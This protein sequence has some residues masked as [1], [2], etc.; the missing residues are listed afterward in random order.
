MTKLLAVL[1][2]AAVVGV[3][4]AEAGVNHRQ[5]D[6][7]ARIAHN[8]RTGELTGREAARLRAEQARIRRE[9]ARYRHNDGRLG[10]WERAE[11]AR[12]Q[13]QANRHIFN[14][15]HDGQDR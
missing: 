1:G 13:N 11:L 10:P 15:S 8:V 9:E 5:G 12:E 3:G 2:L 6:Q 14:Q 7:R 4:S